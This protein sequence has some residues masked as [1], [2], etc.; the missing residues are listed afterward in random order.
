MGWEGR[1][2]A[3]SWRGTGGDGDQGA[4]GCLWEAAHGAGCGGARAAGAWAEGEAP[5]QCQLPLTPVCLSFLL[6]LSLSVFL[7]PSLQGWLHHG[8]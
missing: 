7:S 3:Q 4:E 5:G 1:T 2:M 6:L 8:L